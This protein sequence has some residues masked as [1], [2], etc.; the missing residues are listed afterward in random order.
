MLLMG[1]GTGVRRFCFLNAALH[2]QLEEERAR[3]SRANDEVRKIFEEQKDYYT[4]S[5]DLL[6][7][8]MENGM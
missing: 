7:E 6:K 2:R 8:I 1:W 4:I 5:Q 3:L